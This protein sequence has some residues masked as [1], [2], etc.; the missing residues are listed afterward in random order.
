MDPRNAYEDLFELSPNAI[1]IIEGDRFVDCNPAAV[2]M[3]RFPS[4]QALLGHSG[5]QTHPAD[6]SPACQP[7][8]ESSAEKAEKY[9]KI[10]SEQGSHTFEWT[11]LRFDGT[12]LLVEVQLTV[13]KAGERPVVHVVWRDI[14]ERKRLEAELG[15]VQRLEAVGRLAGGIAHDFNNLLMVIVSHAELLKDGFDSGSP[16]PSPVQEIQDAADRA[17]ALTRQL[18][19]FSR[20][21]PAQARATDLGDVVDGVLGL[22]DRL[23]GEHIEIDVQRGDGPLTVM[24][25]P[26][27][28]EQL[29]LNLATN[30]RDAMPRGGRVEISIG[31]EQV[32]EGRSDHL[33]PGAY[34]SLSVGDSGSGMTREQI[35]RAFDPYYTTKATGKGTGLGL[36]TVHAI[37]EQNFGQVWI[38]SEPG[39]GA[40]IRVL[41]PLSQREPEAARSARQ[42]RRQKGGGETILLVEDESSIRTLFETGLRKEG[43]R[44]M[45]AED[46]QEALDL[47]A[48]RSEA[49]DLLVTDV[50][51]PRL[52]GPELARRLSNEWPG[53]QVLFMSGY[54]DEGN[55]SAI[56]AVHRSRV[57]Q[58]PFPPKVLHSEIR[59]ML[60]A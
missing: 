28:L 38:E 43:Y 58:K 60:D 37:V 41:L 32:D 12:D 15:R 10:A 24:A 1:L 26:S 19:A 16:D 9:L 5:A 4:K 54:S 23:I 18:L 3:L 44:V 57:L 6:I 20:G 13:A 42:G 52:S 53:L 36:A 31:R 22:L 56:R 51:M 50:V 7:D 48:G 30:A 55:L 14:S 2:E 49:I 46:G 17:A 47:V 40:C 29:V 8:G 39:Q 27:Q 45:S 33:A 34:V 11:H 35:D 59:R 25:D 21:Q